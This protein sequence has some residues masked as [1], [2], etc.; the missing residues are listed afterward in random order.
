MQRP[1]PLLLGIDHGLTVTKAVIFDA[2]G[3]PIAVARRRLGDSRPRSRHVERDMGAVWSA[4]ADAIAEA[5][6]SSGR[7]ASDIHAVA[8]TAYG[9]G[10]FMLDAA[11]RPLGPA[12]LSLDSRASGIAEAW[13]RDGVADAA[14]A[15]T[16][17]APH[18][19]ATS[20]LLAW[21]RQ[22]DPHCF[23]RI[24][25]VLGAKDWLRLC[26]TGTVGTDRTEASAAF[27]ELRSQTYSAAALDLFGLSELADSLP[28][29]AHPTDVVGYI[30]A[31][32]ARRTGLVKGTP[33]A[34]G[35]HDVT[36]SALG[37]GGHR[38][39]TADIVA[40]TYSINQIVADAPAIDA[41]WYCRNAITAGHWN[42]MAISPASAVNYDWFLDTLCKADRAA[43]G[44]AVHAVLAPEVDAA[45]GRSTT[46]MF[47]PWLFGSPYGADASGSFTGLHGWHDRGD[48]LCAVLE[49]I[50]FNHRIHVDA[51]HDGF[52]FGAARLTGGT[53]R[54]PA[55]A[56][57]M[58]D[59]LDLPVTVARVEEPAA[60][61]AALC[62]GVAIGLYA[63]VH[64][65]PD[66]D[67]DAI[68]Y[69][70]DPMRAGRLAERFGLWSRIAAA[71]GPL[72]ADI[73][74]SGGRG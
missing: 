3:R 60:W 51:L 20:A 46:V 55:F 67:A 50:V 28:A 19:A 62:A 37:I 66:G 64:D 72:W 41:R 49:G 11:R 29:I 74:R 53:S 71:V 43:H 27:T 2:G 58:A 16:G 12:I 17:Q 36:A 24:G 54:S 40:G 73:E 32:A 70:P 26:L 42:A 59:A 31:D 39:G 30:T 38:P 44:D 45:L 25:A 33:V 65:R 52:A 10:L 23:A 1:M 14:M 8:A 69:D 18:A 5:I 34:A 7:P 61:G 6:A 21:V 63:S 22:D 15:L 13:Q 56:Q 57:M 4:T 35:L 47:H 48:M 9:D 68:A